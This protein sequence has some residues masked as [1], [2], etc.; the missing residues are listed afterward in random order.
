MSSMWEMSELSHPID[1]SLE[2]LSNNPRNMHTRHIETIKQVATSAWYY[3]L[4]GLDFKTN[5]MAIWSQRKQM[6]FHFHL[7][8]HSA[9]ATVTSSFAEIS[10]L[11]QILDHTRQKS[12]VESRT[13]LHPKLLEASEQATSLSGKKEKPF[14]SLWK[15]HHH[16]IRSA[17]A[18]ADNL[19]IIFSKN[20]P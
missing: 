12:A 7:S 6:C 17:F 3:E 5:T 20:K 16:H 18:P 11:S 13:V 1:T 19:F 10:I 4:V 8:P 9:T 2:T 15:H 14:H